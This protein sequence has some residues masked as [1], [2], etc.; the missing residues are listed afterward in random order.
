MPKYGRGVISWC[1]YQLLVGGQN[2]NRIQ[3]SLL[4]LFGLR[5]PNTMV[6]LFKGAVAEYFKT[7]YEKILKD[8][9]RGR[10]IHIDE[11][12]VN[13][14]K[15]KGYVWVLASTESVYFF[16]RTSREGSFLADMLQRF[17]GVL[18]S[19]FYT[20]YDALDMLQQ[21]CLIHLMRDMNDDLLKHPFDDE[22]KSIANKFSSLLKDIVSTIDRYGLKRRH[23]NKYRIRAERFC[24]W[25]INQ[26]FKSDPSK[27][28]VRRIAKYRR[29]MFA[30]LAYD[31]IPWN[32]NNAEPAIKSTANVNQHVC[33]IRPKGDDFDSAFLAA[34]LA[35]QSMQDQI[36]NTENGISR[37]ALNF[38]Q[39][40]ELW[41]T[42]PPVAEQQTIAVLINGCSGKIDGLIQT[43]SRAID[44]LKEFRT[45]L[46]SA[47]VTGKIDVRGEVA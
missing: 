37:D 6:Y 8:L 3:R 14:Q 7:G 23:L 15:D 2:L 42:C 11:T 21:R 5:L 18:V 40:S 25:V 29:F 39:I 10:L 35:S 12:T 36:F 1:I 24:D 17:K 47:A 20:A 44:H 31:G 38:E 19:D 32:N 28:Y 45:A 33:V 4:D 34:A 22:L 16:Y 27:T 41:V 30:F 46:I 43:V 13:L 26:P 9:L